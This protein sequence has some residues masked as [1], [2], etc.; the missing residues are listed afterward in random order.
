MFTAVK[1]ESGAGLGQ[2]V[3]YKS[4][5]LIIT[6]LPLL[7]QTNAGTEMDIFSL[8][9][10]KSKEIEKYEHFR[11]ES[12]ELTSYRQLQLAVT[13]AICCPVLNLASG[14]LLHIVPSTAHENS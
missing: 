12:A 1:C 4:A 3:L 6:V 10:S 5:I 9:S 11:L 8:L 7:H 2:D 13:L 14:Q